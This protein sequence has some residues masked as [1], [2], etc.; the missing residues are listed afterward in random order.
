MTITSVVGQSEF[1]V[2]S[3]CKSKSSLVGVEVGDKG[4]NG[5][6]VEMEVADTTGIDSTVEID[7]GVKSGE[8]VAVGVRGTFPVIRASSVNEKINHSTHVDMVNKQFRERGNNALT[9]PISGRWRAR[10]PY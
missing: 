4:A 9:K 3:R 2:E 7:A 10:K 6:D 1:Q 8:G 5:V